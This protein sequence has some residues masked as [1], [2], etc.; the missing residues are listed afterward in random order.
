MISLMRIVRKTNRQWR[1][2]LLFCWDAIFNWR[3]YTNSYVLMNLLTFTMN[4]MKWTQRIVFHWTYSKYTNYLETV[5]CL[6]LKPV[7]LNWIDYF[8]K[9]RIIN[10]YW[11]YWKWTVWIIRHWWDRRWYKMHRRLFMFYWWK[12]TTMK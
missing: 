12:K 6:L 4:T 8:M 10:T 3:R 2:C 11:T 5:D 7:Y 1:N 9:G